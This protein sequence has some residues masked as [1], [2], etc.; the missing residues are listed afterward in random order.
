MIKYLTAITGLLILNVFSLSAQVVGDEVGIQAGASHYFGDINPDYGLNRPGLSAGILGRYSFNNRIAVKASFNYARV[1]GFDADSDNEFQL[2]RNLD[3]KTDILNG[4]AQIEFNFLPF[5]HGDKDRFFTPYLF[6][7]ASLTYF[8]P[9]A[10]LN[11]TKYALRDLGTEGQ[12]EGDEYNTTAGA[13]LYG[14]GIK[15]SLNYHWSIN[16]ELSMHDLFTDYL[17]DV[18]TVY[19]DPFALGFD[20]GD[21]AVALSDRS[22]ASEGQPKIGELG[23]Q[24]GN[25]ANNDSYAILNVGITYFLGQLKCPPISKTY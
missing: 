25:S 8:N 4:G 15:L 23:R 17:D 19:P 20:R 11:G 24:R 14:G 1:S 2:R 10:E 9:K 13:W 22:I 18:S 3:F 5:V 6:G 7:G 12:D 21:V 16:V